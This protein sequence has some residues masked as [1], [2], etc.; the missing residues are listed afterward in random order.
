MVKQVLKGIGKTADVSRL[1]VV[2]GYQPDHI[3]TYGGV[4]VGHWKG[5]RVVAAAAENPSE[6]VRQ[7]AAK[8]AWNSQRGLAVVLA[9]ARTL[10][11]AAPRVGRPGTT[12]TLTVELDNPSRF[13]LEQLERLR[14][15][16]S[17]N[18]LSHALW[19]AEVL[20]SEKVTERFFCA[21]R[22]IYERM[23]TAP[24]SRTTDRERRMLALL[25]L[26]RILFLYFVQ[27][28]GWLNRDPCYLRTLFDRALQTSSDFHRTKLDPLFFGT[29]NR[30]LRQRNQQID[31][32]TIPY[33]NGGLFQPHPIER[34]AGRIH[35]PNELWRDAFDGL[36]EKFR[37]C[38]REDEEVEAIAPD[39]LGRVFERLMEGAERQVSGTFYTPESVV[40][41]LVEAT[42]QS[43]L[44][45]RI[46]HRLAHDVV[47]G[48][49][50][51]DAEMRT[52][53][54]ALQ[55]L[56]IL[57][58][59]VG[60]GAFLL[61]ALE[62]LTRMRCALLTQ[63]HQDRSRIRRD[64]MRDNLMGIDI[65]PVAVHLAELRLWLAVVADDPTTEIRRVAPLPNLDGVVRQGDTLLDPLGAARRF[66]HG[67][68]NAWN[69]ATRSVGTARRSLFDSGGAA[70]RQDLRRLRR[71][72]IAVARCVLRQAISSVQYA[73][74]DLTAILS[75]RDLFGDP[76]GLT[77]AQADR[78]KALRSTKRDLVRAQKQ[79]SEGRIPFFSFEIQA[80]DVIADGGF[81][82]VVGNPPWVRAERLPPPL[83]HT[84]QERFSWWR[85]SGARGYAH[86]PDLS[87]AFLQ[88]A[89]ELVAPGGT[90]GLLLPSKVT[91]AAYG[92]V[93]RRG[94]V[95]E[96]SITIV[97]RVS[98]RDAGR[99]GATTYPMGVVVK[100]ELPKPTHTIQL[101]F[102]ANNSLSQ[103]AL[104]SSGPWIL[105]PNNVREAL[106]ELR[107][108]GQPLAEI[109][110][111]ALGVKTGADRIFIGRTAGL[112]GDFGNVEFADRSVVIESAMLRP[113]LRG[114]DVRSFQ[115]HPKHV[116]VWTHAESGAPLNKIPRRAA[117][118]L[119]QHS[120]KL[121]SRT[122]Y[123]AGPFWS[124]FR[125]NPA[126]L[127]NR[128]VWADIAKHPRAVALD[129]T[130]ANR[131]IPLNTCY[132]A[133]APNRGTALTI[134]AVFNSCWAR[135]L[136]YAIADEARGGYRRI[137]ARV[138]GQMPVPKPGPQ[139]SALCELSVQAHKGDHV[140]STDLDEAVAEAL[141]LSA[142]AR[143]LLRAVATHHG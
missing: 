130:D 18:A 19:V 135:A 116:I 115:A 55:R 126:L 56:R 133:S 88:R 17:S 6:A 108:S 32:G 131:A 40:K 70:Q 138:A 97:H 66:I 21:F 90:V 79:V 33:L 52:A 102:T 28:K 118:Y 27:Q 54:I 127:K 53:S 67:I 25:S 94:L 100:K 71:T 95:R 78:L 93:A 62:T 45:R 120:G 13:A 125:V 23:V 69:D 8:L 20:S 105:L 37:F 87:V 142:K 15:K 106:E 99:F 1:F 84:L 103:A 109:A 9:R 75:G 61:G 68:G 57:D 14:P 50:L 64:I 119:K 104:N 10:T 34:R 92:E 82:A 122:D 29:L 2:L 134:A 35:Y 140:S 36:F 143:R 89:L 44:T 128:V 123:R 80:P 85:S 107:C 98:E 49:D 46:P 121:K 96:T 43:A 74:E 124:L 59:A 110:T 114:R 111:P 72:E 117:S 4:L 31:L 38:V 139:G 3:A 11:L 129:E 86:L 113:A 26:T 60:S 77:R 7:L 39:M 63:R 5:F 42:I 12:R 112:D 91:S 24:R 132:V 76:S 48:A 47:T 73:I 83:R 41:Q 51:T 81:C 137:N 30:P 58:P 65:N 141:R 22:Q 101:G 16:K 136:T